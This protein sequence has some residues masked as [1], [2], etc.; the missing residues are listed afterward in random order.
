MI[1]EARIA[2][3]VTEWLCNAME[4]ARK[5]TM[6]NSITVRVGPREVFYGIK[7]GG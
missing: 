7:T 1:P 2:A 5:D 4:N 6:I 3:A